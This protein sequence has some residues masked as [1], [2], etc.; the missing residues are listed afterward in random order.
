MKVFLSAD[1]DALERAIS[2]FKNTATVEA[3]YGDRTVFGSVLTLCHHGKWAGNPA[4][5][6]HNEPVGVD[7]IGLSHI[8]LDALGGVLA[9]QGR[10]PEFRHFWMTAALVDLSGP[11]RLPDILKPFDEET[12]EAL[13]D[14]INAFW[15]WA[16]RNRPPTVKGSEV[17]EVSEYIYKAYEALT[18]ILNG[19]EDLLED[20]REFEKQSERLNEE[21]FVECKSGVIVRV[22]PEFVN[23]FYRPPK[24]LGAKF[25]DVAYAVVAFNTRTGSI[26]VSFEDSGMFSLSAV[27]IVQELW[28]PEAGGRDGIAGSPRGVR[29]GLK[30]L[31]DAAEAV[32]KA[33]W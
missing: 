18:A 1:P 22:S 25:E 32:R 11:H 13:K 23:M 33:L 19:D 3:E 31:Y 14:R 20:G 29:M 7:A 5:C 4:P 26:T 30:D 27:K 21:S 16:K 2:E 10:K 28:G 9:I 6:M 12:A 24:S 15:A 17:K 8:D